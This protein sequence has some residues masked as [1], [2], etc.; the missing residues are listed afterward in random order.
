MADAQA[1][2]RQLGF[3]MSAGS[4]HFGSCDACW[5]PDIL[6]HFQGVS[7]IGGMELSALEQ[8]TDWLKVETDP[9]QWILPA[10]R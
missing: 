10:T 5:N 4:Q 3:Q 9:F 7:A 8:E 2:G 1:Q 6:S